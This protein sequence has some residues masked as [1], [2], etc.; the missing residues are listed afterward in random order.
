MLHV[1]SKWV[2]PFLLRDL[3]RSVRPWRDKNSVPF[4]QRR[5]IRHSPRG[6]SGRNE[7]RPNPVSV[8]PEHPVQLV[9]RQAVRLQVL[10]CVRRLE[11]PLPD[12]VLREVEVLVK[13]LIVHVGEP[14]RQG[15]LFFVFPQTGRVSSRRTLT[16]T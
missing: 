7:A 12:P 3:Q 14:L 5:A 15:S 9:F 6:R 2:S 8:P 16:H 4:I 10:Q 1:E 13:R 11:R